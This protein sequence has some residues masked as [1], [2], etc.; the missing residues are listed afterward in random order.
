MKDKNKAALKGL[1]DSLEQHEKETAYSGVEVDKE[2]LR[3]LLR[4]AQNS[5]HIWFE[6]DRVKWTGARVPFNWIEE[7]MLGTVIIESHDDGKA[8]V[9][10]DGGPGDENR[11]WMFHNEIKLAK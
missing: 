1:K 5:A 4:W 6:G 10:W 11:V 2:E 9:E 8:R 7:G 3:T